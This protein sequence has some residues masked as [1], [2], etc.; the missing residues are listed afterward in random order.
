MRITCCRRQAGIGGAPEQWAFPPTEWQHSSK[1]NPEHYTIQ[2]ETTT[3]INLTQSKSRIELVTCTQTK[4]QE[5]TK[6]QI[7][8]DW[9]CHFF[10]F[11]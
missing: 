11:Q 2:P 10:S 7:S 5:I 9:K 3:Y 8:W 6:L 4:R 1:V